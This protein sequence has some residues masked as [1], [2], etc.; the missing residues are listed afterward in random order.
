MWSIVT[1]LWFFF[2]AVWVV[3]GR[4]VSRHTRW[5][6]RPFG[7]RMVWRKGRKPHSRVNEGWTPVHEQTGPQS[8]LLYCIFMRKLIVQTIGRQQ[9]Q[10]KHNVLSK[11]PPRS[12]SGSQTAISDAT[13]NSG[14]PQAQSTPPAPAVPVS[15][16]SKYFPFILLNFSL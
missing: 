15:S 10:K 1:Y 4:F 11:M 13:D 14:T 6:S 2:V 5:Y 8:K 7:W 3:P 9:V 16:R 12:P